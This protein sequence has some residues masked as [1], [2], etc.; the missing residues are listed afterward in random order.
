MDVQMPKLDG[1]ETTIAIRRREGA[2]GGHVPIIAVTAHAMARDR[3]RCMSA[4]MDG[5]LTKPIRPAML[6]DA[7]ARL[8]IAPRE[9]QVP[10]RSRR[11][12]LDR[13]ALL[14]QVGGSPELLGEIIEL[15]HRNCAG[16]LARTREAIARRDAG[17]YAF[18][19]HTLRGM[20]RSLAADAAHDLA[21]GLESLDLE[22]EQDQARSIHAALEQEVRNLEIELASL[23][24]E[25][26]AAAAGAE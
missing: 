1:I 11:A 13:A 17:E 5:Y 8:R 15:F 22:K 24:G 7:I 20:F 14:D 25:P 3:E 18:G 12:T 10:K 26:A 16:L 23:A 21:E 4:G 6:L 19:M 2:T 9:R